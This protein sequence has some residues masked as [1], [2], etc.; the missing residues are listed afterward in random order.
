MKALP[1]A[2][3]KDMQEDKEALF[4]ALDTVN[5]VDAFAPMLENAKF[6]VRRMAEAAAGGFINATDCADYLIKKGL[7]SATRIDNRRD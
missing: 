7:H 4:D 5:L 3:S 2:Y 1:L 6:D